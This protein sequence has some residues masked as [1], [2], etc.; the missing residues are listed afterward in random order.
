MDHAPAQDNASL[1]TALLLRARNQQLPL[2]ELFQVAET[3]SAGGQRVLAAELYKAWIAYNDSNPLLHF[4]YFNYSVTL[5]QMDDLAGSIQALQA[6]LRINPQFGQAHINLG[7]A[8]EDSGLTLQAIQQWRAY[9]EQTAEITAE[10]SSHRLMTLQHIGRVMEGAGLLEEAETALWQAIELR[11]D[12][13]EAGQHW[14]S[15]RQHQCKWPVI[16]TSEHVTARNLVDAMSP[17]PLGCYSDDPLFQLA[18]A[19]RY[20]TFL[21][22]RPDTTGFTRQ[23]PRIKSGTGQRLRIGYVSSDLRDHAV[24]FALREVLELHDKSQVEIFA[25][26]CGEARTGDATQDRIKAAVD[27][28]RDIASITDLQAANQIVADEIDIL[29]DVNGFTKHARTKIF[30]YRPAPVIVAFCGYPGSMGSPYHQYLIADDQIVP[31]E[32]EIYYTEKVLRIP[33]NQPIDRKRVIAKTPTRTE[34]GLPEDAFVFACFN[35]M[36]KITAPVFSRWM[37]ILLATPNSV[38]W[39]LGGPDVVNQRLRTL[40]TERGVAPERLIFAPKAANPHHLARI[41]LADLFLDTFPYGAHSTA[42]DAITMGLPVLSL[43][44]K[45]FASR[46]CSSIVVAAGI[47]ELVCSSPNDYVAKAITYARNPAALK[48]VRQSLQDQRDGSV[49]RDI[50]ALVRRLEEL[51]WQMQGECERGETPV[52]DLTNLDVYYEIGAE[53]MLEN[54]DF[55]DEGTYRQRYLEKLARW[56]E[57]SPLPRDPRLW[58]GPSA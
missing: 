6:C 8:M 12:K 14:L 22:G 47:P 29:V 33:C 27:G 31:P 17:L 58:T 38:L 11:P 9:A 44:G 13:P 16:V 26:Y 54:T 37:D 25:Y 15:L 50:P 48:V 19:Y 30:A 57:F 55:Q 40:A 10:R 28:W 51:F 41:A 23:T 46:F 3:L 20:N 2:G 49:L 35:G 36:Q 34:A 1:F 4:V 5:R 43:P 7:R 42:A 24:G 18:K 53:L 32:A 39:L 52:P 21:V 56:N 45:T